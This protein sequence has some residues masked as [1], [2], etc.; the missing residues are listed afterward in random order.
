MGIPRGIRGGI[1]EEILHR[2][3]SGGKRFPFHNATAGTLK[4]RRG[5]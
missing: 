2:E 1:L 4:G 3:R 5:R